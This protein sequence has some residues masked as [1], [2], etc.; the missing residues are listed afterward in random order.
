[1]SKRKSKSSRSTDFSEALKEWEQE[2]PD[3]WTRDEPAPSVQ[4]KTSEGSLSDEMLKRL[5]T[6]RSEQKKTA[7]KVVQRPASSKN[8]PAAGPH[9]TP[10]RRMTEAELMREAFDALDEDNFD[11]T[12]KFRGEGYRRAMDVEIIDQTSTQPPSSQSPSEA[13]R[14]SYN[15]E[16]RAFEAFMA[17][18]EV[19]PLAGPIDKLRDVIRERPS[20]DRLSRAQQE[21]WKERVA[22]DALHAPQLSQAQRKLLKRAKKYGAIPELNLRHY[23]KHEALTMLEQ[24]VRAHHVRATRFVRIITGKGK[25]SQDHVVIKPAVLE[26]CEAPDNAALLIDYSPSPDESGNYGVVILELRRP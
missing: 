23:R 4:D 10:K 12:A 18:A 7:K 24:F 11:P 9:T 26:W 16:D 13:V 19:K 14:Q 15:T 22:E 21:A 17:N 25:R 8:A 3:A 6:L 2:N 5:Q 20:W 1:M